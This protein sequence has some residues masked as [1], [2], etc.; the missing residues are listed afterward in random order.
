MKYPHVRKATGYCCTLCDGPYAKY[1]KLNKKAL[2]KRDK[3]EAKKK[4]AQAVAEMDKD[5]FGLD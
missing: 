1:K 4:A 2:K 3:D 5:G